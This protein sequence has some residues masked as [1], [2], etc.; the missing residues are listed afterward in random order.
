MFGSH[1]KNINFI[2]TAIPVFLV[3]SVQGVVFPDAAAGQTESGIIEKSL[4]Q[5][6]PEFG[7]PP[8]EELP[9]IT[10]KDS[11]SVVDAGAGPSFFVRKIEITGNRLI[12]DEELA[13]IVDIGDGLEMTLG[14]LM[15][16]ANEVTAHYAQKGFFLARAYVPEQEISAGVIKM[17]IVEGRV[18][19]I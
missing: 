17:K 16:I 9:S 6:R 8:E 14:L 10:V 13:P 15:L 11:R 2:A 18:G 4:R 1:S 3:W 19:R 12:S 5:S 7:P